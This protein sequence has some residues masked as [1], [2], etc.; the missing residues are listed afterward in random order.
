MFNVD[1]IWAFKLEETYHRLLYSLHMQLASRSIKA[2][3]KAES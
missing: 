1:L 2:V 3:D